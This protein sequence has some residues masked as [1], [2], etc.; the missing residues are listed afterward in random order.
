MGNAAAG[1]ILYHFWSFRVTERACSSREW[2][3]LQLQLAARQGRS[4]YLDTVICEQLF[5]SSEWPSVDV[6]LTGR[7][8]FDYAAEV[9]QARASYDHLRA[10]LGIGDLELPGE[11]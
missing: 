6:P 1:P 8:L 5:G 10:S 11:K 7:P 3:T 9:E 2:C 4:E